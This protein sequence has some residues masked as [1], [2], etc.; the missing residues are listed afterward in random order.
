MRPSKFSFISQTELNLVD[1]NILKEA[2]VLS[3]RRDDVK[4]KQMQIFI[5]L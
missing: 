2:E 4:K 5:S 1:C 3:L